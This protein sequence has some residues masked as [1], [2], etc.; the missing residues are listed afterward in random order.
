V[1]QAVLDSV[2]LFRNVLAL[3]SIGNGSG[4]LLQA[5]L[6][7]G[8]G[9]RSVLVEELEGLGRLVAVEGVL[10]L[11]NGRRNLKTAAKESARKSWAGIIRKAYS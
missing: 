6:L 3:L 1:V 10:E 2:W 4:F 7:L 11:G 8:L 9:L 5:L